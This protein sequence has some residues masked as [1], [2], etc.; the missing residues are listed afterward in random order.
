MSKRLAPFLLPLVP[1]ALAACSGAS[2]QLVDTAPSD[3]GN[4][5]SNGSG[6]TSSAGNAGN[7]NGNNGNGNGN[8]GNNGSDEDAGGNGNGFDPGAAP[9]QCPA[10]GAA[11]TSGSG[12]SQS[13]ATPF[14]T[15][16]CGS[17][18][19]GQSYFWTFTLPASTS[20]FALSFTGGL[21]I[22]LTLDG[23]T[24]NVT[25][26]AALPF[27]TK[28]PYYVQITP[29]GNGATSYVLVVEEK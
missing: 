11:Q 8:G 23:T 12:D 6:A 24:V 25:P 15:V 13:D 27:R 1:L 16:A 29:Q 21:Q 14:D 9:S 10:G 28:D 3:G 18:D 17:L 4:A 19:G 7:G 2:A 20:K 5:A 22:E 26:G